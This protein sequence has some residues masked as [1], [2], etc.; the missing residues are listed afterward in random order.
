MLAM[1]TRLRTP[2]WW[3]LLPLGLGA[4]RA[5]ARP[6]S[7]EHYDSGRTDSS[8]G[9]DASG[10]VDL[11]FWLVIRE[12]R[13]GIPLVL[14]AVVAYLVYQRTRGDASTRRALDRAEA[15]RRTTVSS[16]SVEA[17]VS[18]VK[19]AD[20][21]FELLA[22][23]DR[24]RDLVG[25][26]NEAWFRRNLEPV[27]R[28]LSDA[29]WQRLSAQLMLIDRQGLRDALAELELLDLQVIG[30][31]QTPAYQTLHV[32]VTASQRDA[33]APASFSDEEA[34][35]LARRQ[36]PERYTEVWSLVRR[37]GATGRGSWDG[38]PNCGA[39]FD[40]GA[41]NRCQSCG[42]IVN[43]GAHDWV[44]A[45]IT[46]GSEYRASQEAAEGLARARQAD[47]A[48]A[49]E[50]VEDRASLLFWRWVE[51][52]ASGHT[53]R[54]V[55]LAAP[56][57]VEAL[58]GEL[59]GLHARGQRRTFLECAV[60][61]VEVRR[62]WLDGDAE[63]VAVEVRWSARLGVGPADGRPPRLPTLPQRS[64]L[65][66]RRKAGA[67]SS[68]ERG[69]STCRCPSCGAPLTDNGQPSCEYCGA[70]LASGELDWILEALLPWEGWAAQRGPGDGAGTAPGPRMP[71]GEERER[72]VYLMAAMA[73]ADGQVDARERQLL[74][75]AATRWRV[76]WANVELALSASGGLFE[77][78]LQRGSAEAEAFLGEL[79]SMARA[80]GVIDRRERR[81][82]ESAAAHLGLAA[83]LAELLAEPRA[84]GS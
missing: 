45:E 55:K 22:F 83:R 11:L 10:L 16:A 35:A 81:L 51:A 27:R 73:A 84:P 2:G 75:L 56:A 78:L 68:A 66:L 21:G 49:V 29:T 77:K 38:C 39:P 58:Q 52:Q 12:P 26:V 15:D 4:A 3:W 5:L 44:V 67:T 6:G 54:L 69:L 36:P 57:L 9:G 14:V 20:P 42:A 25:R 1:G 24:V 37:P 47:P 59:D 13:V 50:V 72:L 7:G 79:V 8:G 61:A 28:F 43:S 70:A 60:G 18:A 32:R 30:L 62:F 74:K 40:G 17:W 63:R 53:E 31:E 33:D 64:A 82:L 76:P 41:A 80:D 19:G 48:L 65:V 23:L 71:D 34:R 46:Q